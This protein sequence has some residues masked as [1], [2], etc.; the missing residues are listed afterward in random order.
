MLVEYDYLFK[1][2]RNIFYCVQNAKEENTFHFLFCTK[3][4]SVGPTSENWKS[5]CRKT[6][7]SYAGS[8]QLYIYLS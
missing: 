5:A 8:M 4:C 7:I 6:T 1:K 3:E 2:Q